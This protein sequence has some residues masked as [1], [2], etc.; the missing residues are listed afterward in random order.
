MIKAQH[1]PLEE[2]V[3][4]LSGYRRVLVLGCETCVAVCFAGGAKE[5][6]VIASALR[7]RDREGEKEFLEDTVKRQCEREFL[8]EKRGLIESADAVLSLACGVGMNVMAEA[9]PRTPILPG[10]N[11]SF[12][13]ASPELGVFAERCVAC[14]NC[15][16]HLTGGL[17]PIAR[18]AKKLF[19]G[20][21]GGS[22]G[23]RCEVSKDLPCI[24]NMII[25]R[26]ARLDKLHLLEEVQ[27]PRDW[28]TQ[29]ALGPRSIVREDLRI[30]L[31]EE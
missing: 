4:M 13:G 27:P 12:L 3:G 9:F 8:E 26:L 30:T 25:E 21:C 2:I 23:G 7:L 29:D 1:K 20:P 31:P 24:W 19:N 10:N 11:T 17:C 5:V 18:C 22:E 28:A 16:L 14:G 6:S 15:I